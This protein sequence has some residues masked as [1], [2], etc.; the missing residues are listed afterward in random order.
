MKRHCRRRR[1]SDALKRD[2]NN[3]PS[4]A[5]VAAIAAEAGLDANLMLNWQWLHVRAEAS[6]VIECLQELR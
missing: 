4:D 1:R 2:M 6:A 3:L 5:S